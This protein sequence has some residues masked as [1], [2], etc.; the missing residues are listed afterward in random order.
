MITPPDI[1]TTFRGEGRPNWTAIAFAVVKST[2]EMPG[3][4]LARS[5]QMQGG[6]RG[7][8]GAYCVVREDVA[9]QRQRSRCALIASPGYDFEAAARIA[10][11]VFA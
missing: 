5:A 1:G 10:A 3:F 8:T 6:A 2:T 7:H 9:P 11:I 4:W